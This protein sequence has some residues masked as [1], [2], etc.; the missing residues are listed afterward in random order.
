M[1]IIEKTLTKQ[2]TSP[3]MT[4]GG[5]PGN[6]PFQP[7]DN[8]P[9]QIQRTQKPMREKDAPIQ[10]HVHGMPRPV[11]Q[12]AQVGNPQSNPYFQGQ[13]STLHTQP[14]LSGQQQAPITFIKRN[15]T[16]I[17]NPHQNAAILID[18]INQDKGLRGIPAEYIKI[19]SNRLDFRNVMLNAFRNK[20][21]TGCIEIKMQTSYIKSCMV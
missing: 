6:N 8:N 13:F 16:F 1:K 14:W 7:F 20:D 11:Q 3:L 15:Q 5:N 4:G 10:F 9:E 17:G 19:I 12:H 21:Q 2:N 18:E